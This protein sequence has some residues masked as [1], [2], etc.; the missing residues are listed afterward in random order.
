MAYI[1]KKQTNSGVKPIGSNLF[2]TCTTASATSAKVASMS[3]FDVLVEGVTVHIHFA[4]GNTASSPTLQVGSTE[5]RP[6]VGEWDD[7]GVYSFTYH[8]GLWM[9]NDQSGGGG[10][11]NNDFGKVK[12]GSTIIPS[13]MAEDT[14]ELV[15]GDNITL[16]PDVSGKKVRIDATFTINV[17]SASATP[18]TSP[19][20]ILPSQGYDY[21]SEVDIDAIPYVEEPNA[22][23]TTVKIG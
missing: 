8:N 1:T 9:M 3:D 17:Q 6:L 21:L 10:T 14:L 5:A 20:T 19:Q 15:A 13:T 4:N 23:G 18:S 11:A 12:V 22:Y 2:G 7:S 16:T